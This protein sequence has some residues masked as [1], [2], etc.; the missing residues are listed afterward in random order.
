MKKA[1]RSRRSHVPIEELNDVIC[2]HLVKNLT[3][4]YIKTAFP[5]L[6]NAI[7]VKNQLNEN[8]KT[9]KTTKEATKFKREQSAS[10][11]YHTQE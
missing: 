3:P 7:G 4:V 6:T 9:S 10:F 1:R 11:I 8:P 2:S 5:F